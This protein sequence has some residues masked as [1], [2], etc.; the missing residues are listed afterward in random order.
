MQLQ[1]I[2]VRFTG[3]GTYHTREF[4]LNQSDEGEGPTLMFLPRAGQQLKLLPR[5]GTT[6]HFLCPRAE[7]DTYFDGP[8][9]KNEKIVT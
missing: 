5:V 8:G 1:K 2:S 7:N 9:G 4:L 6:S 3:M